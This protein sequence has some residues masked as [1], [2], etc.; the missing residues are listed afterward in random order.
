MAAVYLDGGLA[1]ARSLIL[2]ALATQL[3]EARERGA[4][5]AGAGDFKSSLQEYL[6]ARRQPPPVYRVIDQVGPDHDKV[7]TVDV[8][9]SGRLLAN[10]SGRSKKE[11]EQQAARAALEALREGSIDLDDAARG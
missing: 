3:E 2:R 8:H 6:Q 11:A 5:V 7:F 4:A 9:A 10:A 1:A